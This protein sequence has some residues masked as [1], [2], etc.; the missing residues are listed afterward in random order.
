MQIPL[1]YIA[2]MFD[3]IGTLEIYLFQCLTAHKILLH[4]ITSD[5]HL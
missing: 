4:I 2:F 1:E 3:S 5:F